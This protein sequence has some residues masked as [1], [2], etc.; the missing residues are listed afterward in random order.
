MEKILF[1]HDDSPGN[2]RALTFAISLAGKMDAQLL[3]A[4]TFLPAKVRREKV[5]A[6]NTG[7]KLT[8]IPD[9]SPALPESN[10]NKTCELNILGMNA[11]QAAQLINKEGVRMIIKVAVEY[12]TP[13][14]L[15][16]DTLLNHIYC[17]LLL[18]PDNWSL[19]DM[20]RIAYLADLR[21]CQ[22]HIVRYLAN[23]AAACGANLSV[24]HLTKHGM[25]H[26][27]EAY[28]HQL[29]NEQV[30]RKVK[31]EQLGFN[32]T[33]ETNLIKA[34]D[35]LTNGM[36]NDLLVMTK[37]RYHYNELVGPAINSTLPSHIHCPLL[38]FPG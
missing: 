8:R 9:T 14:S 19:K 34:A 1:I 37:N 28:A 11:K 29:F 16:L 26:M 17:P 30:R 6:G 2:F 23:L 35:V 32:Y 22:T 4:H 21:Y 27:D 10:A 7:S 33:R 20:E 15:N 12:H 24:V 36:H 13:T 31:Y 38:I 3:L 25:V 18:I 5:I